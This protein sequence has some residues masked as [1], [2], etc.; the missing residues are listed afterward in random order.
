[1]LTMR[2]A[3]RSITAEK[4]YDRQPAAK[5]YKINTK[6]LG[7]V[8]DSKVFRSTGGQVSGRPSLKLAVVNNILVILKVKQR[9]VMR[10]IERHDSYL[11]HLH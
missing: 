11:V 9:P 1:M 3:T 5:I 10:M 6:H 8:V 2:M 4:T 7:A